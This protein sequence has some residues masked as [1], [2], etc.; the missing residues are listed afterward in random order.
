M[1]EVS[2]AGLQRVSWGELKNYLELTATKLNPWEVSVVIEMSINYCGWF[3]KGKEPDCEC[4]WHSE[5]YNYDAMME[6]N[7]KRVWEGFK[8]LKEQRKALKRK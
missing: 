2:M 3:N 1:F 4:P 6:E 5:A 7:R 8:K